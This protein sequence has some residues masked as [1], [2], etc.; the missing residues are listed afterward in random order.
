MF[1]KIFSLLGLILILSG[2]GQD[3]TDPQPDPQI[4]TLQSDLSRDTSSVDSANIALVREGISDFAFDLYREINASEENLFFS[5]YS[6]SSAFTMLYA[7][8]ANETKTQLHNAFHFLNDDTLH[9]QSYNALDRSVFDNETNLTSANSLWLQVDM[10]VED[11]FLDTL[12]LYYG[13]GVF[14]RDF[15]TAPES[16]RLDIND[17]IFQHTNE[18][19]SDALPEGTVTPSTR[20]VLANTIHFLGHWSTP[21]LSEITSQENFT[22]RNGAVSTV[23]MMHQ[24]GFFHYNRGDDFTIFS[25]PYDDQ[26]H[27]MIILLPDSGALSQVENRLSRETLSTMMDEMNTTKLNLSMPKFEIACTYNLNTSLPALGVTDAFD[28]TKADFS[29]LSTQPL[30]ISSAIHKAVI[31]LDEAGTEAAA[32]TV[33][34]AATSAEPTEPV[35]VTVD[36]PFFFF[37]VDRDRTILFMGKVENP[38][39]S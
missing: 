13:A 20:M 3:T 15:I 1:S 5:P 26:E 18:L 37:I 2:C 7:G 39:K 33:V 16:A 38:E 31:R 23:S 8:A 19:I 32:V 36:R 11:L 35:T 9:H 17:W 6:I 21:F 4:T 22:L 29:A 30:F 25:L 28:S 27:E 24:G 12:A 10:P 14:Q 34:I